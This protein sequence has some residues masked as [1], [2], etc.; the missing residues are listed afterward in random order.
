MAEVKKRYC[1]NG[2]LQQMLYVGYKGGTT[3]LRIYKLSEGPTIKEIFGII[4]F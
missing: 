2:Q 4:N 1:P 3:A